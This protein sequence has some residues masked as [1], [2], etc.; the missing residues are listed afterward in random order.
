[1]WSH[2]NIRLERDG[3]VLQIFR[4]TVNNKGTYHCE[5]SNRAGAD[6]RSLNIQ[7]KDEP[8]RNYTPWIVISVLLVALIVAVMAYCIRTSK[9]KVILKVFDPRNY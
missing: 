2:D 9:E 6:S 1:M 7:F 4:A 5:A 3:Q 8:S